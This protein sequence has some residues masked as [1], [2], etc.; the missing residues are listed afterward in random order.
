MPSS[1]EKCGAIS[2]KFGENTG[3]I[4]SKNPQAGIAEGNGVD[5]G[6][7]QDLDLLKVA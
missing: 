2:T 7:D 5:S 1:L 4:S 6:F 3:K